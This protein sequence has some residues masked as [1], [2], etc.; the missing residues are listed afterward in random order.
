MKKFMSIL[1]TLSLITGTSTAALAVGND[2]IGTPQTMTSTKSATLTPLQKQAREAYLKIHFDD[3]NQ[4][5][6][7]RQQTQ[8]AQDASNV[9]AKQIKDKLKSKTKLDN[10][11]I[12]KLKDLTSQRKVLITQAKELHQHR[13][14]LKKQYKDS[15]KAKDVEK[16]K[17]VQQRILRLNNQV[18]VIKAKVNAIKVQ[19][20]PLKDQLKDIKDVNKTLK[21]DVKN[22]LAQAKT[23]HA[24]IKTQEKEKA[25]LWIT[26]NENI[27]NKDYTTA[28]T[29][30]K[31]IIDK[32]SAILINIKE[33][34][35]ILKQ[36]LS[37]LD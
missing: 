7:L 28:G 3:M 32:K 24:T 26:Y 8:T 33:R 29:T 2:S 4:L 23:I 9:D 31:S 21:D 16:M 36:V 34:I 10:V 37:S 25:Q 22:Q 15:V 1:L 18:G 20:S 5:V 12:T 14:S 11:S 27:K 19:I 6:S 35:T 17:S 30:F 13:L